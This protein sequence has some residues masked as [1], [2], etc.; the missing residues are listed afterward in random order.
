ML[1]A[2]CLAPGWWKGNRLYWV[3]L[4]TAQTSGW[5]L[6]PEKDRWTNH[7]KFLLSGTLS[8]IYA[9]SAGTS[10]S[11]CALALLCAETMGRSEPD[12]FPKH[13]WALIGSLCPS[14]ASQPNCCLRPDL[15]KEDNCWGTGSKLKE[16]DEGF[17]CCASQWWNS[18]QL[19]VLRGKL[20]CGRGGK[21]LDGVIVEITVLKS[22]RSWR[23]MVC[24][25]E[26]R[27]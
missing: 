27:R 8:V 15:D 1:T 13:G 20:V 22:Q 23:V 10:D 5:P 16:E 7:W 25:P 3:F 21:K 11:V 19:M 9:F 26:G 2:E 14:L 4:T 24:V 18:E 17:A 12:N 6:T